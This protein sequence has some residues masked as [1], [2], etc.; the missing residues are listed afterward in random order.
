M[1]F[2]SQGDLV[3]TL[4]QWCGQANSAQDALPRRST[5]QPAGIADNQGDGPSTVCDGMRRAR[6]LFAGLVTLAFLSA[7]IV[8]AEASVAFLGLTFP[9]RVEDAQLGQSHDFEK[10]R[11][12]LGYSVTY[13][14]PRW[15]IDVYI[16]DQRQKSIPDGP[17]SDIVKNQLQQAQGNILELQRRG[18]YAN[19]EIK[20]SYVR[21]DENGQAKFLGAD[22]SYVALEKTKVDSFLCLVGWNNKFVKFRLTSEAHDG[23]EVE[24][25][26]FLAA[27]F[28]I[29][30]P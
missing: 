6:G 2:V 9:D 13:L 4:P 23:S 7:A 17:E 29:L 14:Q 18:Y 20:R 15:K 30:W 12:G 24:A 16:Y 10:D 25:K 8:A 19:V 11:P 22:F 21:R 28:T 5:E 3:T 26:R 1:A 27:W